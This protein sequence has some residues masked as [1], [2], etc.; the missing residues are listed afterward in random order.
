MQ[1]V[2]LCRTAGWLVTSPLAVRYKRVTQ[3]QGDTVKILKAVK[4]NQR[5]HRYYISGERVDAHTFCAERLNQQSGKDIRPDRVERGISAYL[6]P[7]VCKTWLFRGQASLNSDAYKEGHADGVY[8]R[9][10]A[11]VYASLACL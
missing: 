6:G 9:P 3:K 5:E 1:S 11:N 2:K 10:M 7:L 4:I 8:C